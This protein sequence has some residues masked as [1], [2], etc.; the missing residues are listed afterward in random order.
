MTHLDPAISHWQRLDWRMVVIGPINAARQFLFPMVIA[1]LGIGSATDQWPIWAIPLLI[2]APVLVGLVPWLTTR[3]RI[4]DNHFE[5][6][7]GLVFRRRSRVALDRIRSV[8]VE[9]TLI[10][11][12]LAVTKVRIGTGVDETRIELLA[13]G[14][15]EA[16]ALHRL[17][18]DRGTAPPGAVP[19][20]PE[21]PSYPSPPL[22]AL[23]F[24]WLKYAPFSLTKLAIIAGAFGALMQYANDVPFLDAQHVDAAWRWVSGFALGLVIVVVM[25][26][27]LL[28]WV[29]IAVVSYAVQ[30]WDLRL[31]REHGTIRVTAGL[32][33]TRSTTVE[34]RKIRGVRITQDLLLRAVRGAELAT[35]ATGVGHGGVTPVLPPCPL[36]VATGVG[37]LLVQDQAPLTVSIIGHG[38][39]A[40]RRCH[41][42]TQWS[43]VLAAAAVLPVTYFADL[44]WAWTVSV[45]TCVALVA[46]A[47]AENAYR[48]LGHALT[49]RHLVSQSG[50]LAKTRIALERDGIIGWVV[51]QSIFQRRV[52][53]ATLIATTAAGSERV[54]VSDL[55]LAAAVALA[56]HATPGLCD[57]FLTGSDNRPISAPV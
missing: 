40:R 34:E 16:D 22:A 53:L 7:T 10:H 32:F 9:A 50:Y 37:G 55:P 23:D 6:R 1:I 57:Q 31:T 17:L 2:A 56:R 29:V 4:L 11:R 27:A 20:P 5:L 15:Q 33:T 41:I 48:M 38:P 52:G 35:L 13:L 42:R 47:L 44:P 43:T 39:A 46:A 49:H 36:E 19:G 21:A 14:R 45:L 12:I 8:D 30:W 25:V 51:R 26:T 18:L 28:I 24:G 54:T 3:Y